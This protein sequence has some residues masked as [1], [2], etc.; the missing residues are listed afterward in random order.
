M[1]QLSTFYIAPMAMNARCNLRHF[2]YH[3][4][5]CRL[6]CGTKTMTCT[7][8]NHVP[9]FSLTSWHY[10]HERWNFHPSRCCHY[11][12]NT[13]GFMSWILFNLRICCLRSNSSQRKELS[14]QT[15]HLSFLPFS[16]WGVWMFRQLSWCAFTRLCLNA[17][18]NFKG[19]ER[20]PFYVL[21]IFFIK[22]GIAN[23][24]LANR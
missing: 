19:P 1:L 20:P 14:W 18:W 17:V 15:P 21:V 6:P 24:S 10:V 3:C 23:I 22:Q 2:C 12:S 5:R 7:S 9:F 13:N 8:L 4:M 16:N 11:Q